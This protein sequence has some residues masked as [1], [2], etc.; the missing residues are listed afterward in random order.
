MTGL[1]LLFGYSRFSES[2]HQLALA[3]LLRESDLLKE[4]GI[5][6]V[7]VETSVETDKRLF[8]ITISMQGGSNVRL[9][10]KLNAGLSRDQL[11]R[12]KEGAGDE[13]MLYVFLGNSQFYTANDQIAS[14]WRRAEEFEIKFAEDETIKV[15]RASPEGLVD[16]KIIG[17]STMIRAL[18]A[19][20]QTA[21]PAVRELAEAYRRCLEAIGNAFASFAKISLT[22]WTNA[23]WHGFYD[24]VRAN[25]FPAASIG[26]SI[27]FQG[28]RLS[29]G[30]RDL[31][32]RRI[33]VDE[34][35]QY[36]VHLEIEQSILRVKIDVI[37]AYEAEWTKTVREGFSSALLAVAERVGFGL[38]PSRQRLGEEMTIA[39]Y[40][41]DYRRSDS[42]NDLDWNHVANTLQK[43]EELVA[44]A[45][46][47]YN[48]EWGS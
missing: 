13:Q 2:M 10:L 44:E 6:G 33:A 29:W 41:G 31:M 18:S 34:F 27:G 17:L 12:Q 30:T 28:G 37:E 20:A 16:P 5:P 47:Q 4:L 45:V 46:V 48:K 36:G 32:M 22:N 9:E 38:L 3:C 8:D 11:N 24:S 15:R 25:L 40:D 1:D 7:P 43:A 23:H 14:S 35:V 26:L 21:T 42:S 39:V 19:S